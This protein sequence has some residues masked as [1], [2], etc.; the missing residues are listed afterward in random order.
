[1]SQ[2]DG[3]S[4]RP[5][6]KTTGV[7]PLALACWICR[8]SRSL[9]R[10]APPFDS[11]AIGCPRQLVVV[12]VVEVVVAVVPAAFAVAAAFSIAAASAVV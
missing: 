10:S 2:L 5:W 4:Q 9:I 6:M 1:L 12:V 11:S 8:S 3:K 7:R